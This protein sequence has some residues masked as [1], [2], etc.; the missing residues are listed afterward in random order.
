VTKFNGVFE[1]P[2]LIAFR[3]KGPKQPLYSVMFPTKSIWH[4]GSSAQTA[5]SEESFKDD[6][7]GADIYQEWLEAY[8]FERSS[9]E[10]DHKHGHEH[11]HKHGHEHGHD[12]GKACAD[13]HDHCGHHDHEKCDHHEH[14]NHGSGHD[15]DHHHE[16]SDS[17]DHDHSHGHGHD[18]D[19]GHDHSHQDR[20]TIEKNAHELEGE[21]ET[22][23]KIIHKALFKVLYQKKLVT[24]EQIHQTVEK[25]QN[26]GRNL[27][28][29]ELVARAWKDPVFK[30][31]LID[32]RKL[33]A[34][35]PTI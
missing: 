26:A 20:E 6:C 25:L 8:C 1:D 23:G 21:S 18:H 19:A 27:L 32:D 24:P 34:L 17:H 11:A 7:I 12:H 15:H 16:K 13:H 35:F 9:E 10:H 29:A 5:I 14:G 28:G 22:P 30:A 4:S 33:F 2:F 31:R 3:G